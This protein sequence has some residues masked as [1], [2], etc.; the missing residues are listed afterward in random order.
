MGHHW[1]HRVW[2]WAFLHT[3]FLPINPLKATLFSQA[4]KAQK[5]ADSLVERIQGSAKQGTPFSEQ[6][7]TL[8][9]VISAQQ[10]LHSSAPSVA[11]GSSSSSTAP[12][13]VKAGK[14]LLYVLLTNNFSPLSFITIQPAITTLL[15]ANTPTS[16]WS[17]NEEITSPFPQKGSCWSKPSSEASAPSLEVS[18]SLC[19]KWSLIQ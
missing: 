10:Q 16:K 6:H 4:L 3:S 8:L 14:M 12:S 17:T 18:P 2:W 1:Q 9:Y 15:P 13:A 5:V 7:F 19:Y 11:P